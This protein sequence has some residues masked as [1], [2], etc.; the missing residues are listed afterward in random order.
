MEK[1]FVKP[2]NAAIIVPNP[3]NQSKPLAAEG[4]EVNN[5][6]YWKR[7]KDEGD[8]TIG[9]PSPKAKPKAEKKD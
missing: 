1:I 3:E 4:E 7:R 9:K 2:T 5:T 8:V 6:R